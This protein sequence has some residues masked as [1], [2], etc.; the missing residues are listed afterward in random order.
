MNTLPKPRSIT[1]TMFFDMFNT[2]VVQV[3]DICEYFLD[4]KYETAKMKIRKHE[5]PLPAF[6][7]HEPTANNAGTKAPWFVHVDDLAEFY[8]R[9][10]AEAKKEWESI[11]GQFG[12]H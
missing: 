4:M 10:R 9:K 6:Q 8:D 3:K 5:F 12:R 11:Y 7:S 1:R 2:P